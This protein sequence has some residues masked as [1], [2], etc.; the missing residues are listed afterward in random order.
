MLYT[1]I[2]FLLYTTP[3]FNQ[4]HILKQGVV[5]FLWLDNHN[6]LTLPDLVSFSNIFL[7]QVISFMKYELRLENC[8][9]FLT[10]SW[11]FFLKCHYVFIYPDKL[12]SFLPDV[13]LIV[14]SM[15]TSFHFCL[16]H[17][18]FFFC[19]I[20]VCFF[21][22]FIDIVF[23]GQRL[24]FWQKKNIITRGQLKQRRPWMSWGAIVTVQ[25]VMLGKQLA[26]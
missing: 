1:H 3:S 17:R 10:C 15:Y 14:F 4:Q 24:N 9:F 25:A 26:D 2:V 7:S 12:C 21:F 23:F 8:A 18:L 19:D 5:I 6:C 22:F 16:W 20:I 11:F 13:A